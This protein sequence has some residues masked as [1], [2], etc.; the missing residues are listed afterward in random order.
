[1]PGT[2]GSLTIL[3]TADNSHRETQLCMTMTASKLGSAWTIGHTFLLQPYSA[4]P[5]VSVLQRL[6]QNTPG[7]WRVR[8]SLQIHPPSLTDG[9]VPGQW[10]SGP[11]PECPC[12]VGD[13]A[14]RPAKKSSFQECTH[15]IR[16]HG[17]DGAQG[18]N[19]RMH[20]LHIHVIGSDCVGH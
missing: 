9:K 13:A 1:M 4:N 10:E 12:S 5:Q 14:L 20:V 6:S 18:E 16:L 11:W 8:I 17:N 7:L 2:D 3:P 19:E 15:L